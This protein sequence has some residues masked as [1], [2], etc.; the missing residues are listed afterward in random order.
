MTQR[1]TPSVDKKERRWSPSW[2][3]VGVWIPALVYFI[4]SRLPRSG[5]HA[6]ALADRLQVYHDRECLS[7]QSEIVYSNTPC[8]EVKKSGGGVATRLALS[9]GLHLLW[10][11]EEA[12]EGTA[13]A[14]TTTL[15]VDSAWQH[16]PESGR[17]AVVL[18]QANDD[19][20]VWRWETGGGPIPLGRTLVLDQ[21]GCRS[22]ACPR[23]DTTEEGAMSLRGV[24]GL[25]VTSNHKDK[26]AKPLLVLAEWGEGRIIRLEVETGARTPL[27]MHVPA[28]DACRPLAN[29]STIT[30]TTP[31][32]PE[33]WQRLQQPQDLLWTPQGDLLFLDR[34]DCPH[35]ST[36]STMVLWRRRAAA[37]IPALSDLRTSRQAHAWTRLEGQDQSDDWDVLL[38][39][40]TLGGL[41]LAP[42]GQSVY[43]TASIPAVGVVIFHVHLQDEDDD[44]ED[45][46]ESSSDR[47]ASSLEP[48]IVFRLQRYLPTALEAGPLV[49]TASGKLVLA[50]NEGLALLLPPKVEASLNN[51]P[52]SSGAYR[53]AGLVPLPIMNRPRITSLTLGADN[54]LYMTT[55][56][57]LWRM[58][59]REGPPSHKA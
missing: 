3:W 7:L 26:D 2:A 59:L 20:R 18:S 27:V 32:P 8:Q 4:S 13:A 25:T 48:R 12:T 54:Y 28:H 15:L 38:T 44:D 31:S 29:N 53:L 1:Q 24:G 56:T 36:T 49:V 17:G 40:D 5:L 19:G 55:E 47:K 46:E 23:Q 16:N 50:T 58:K 42:D 9:Q 33:N 11:A 52:N 34:L 35:A 43:V 45:D 10:N 41:T 39:A 30:T 21:A 14:T 37:Q 57:R 22:Q 51:K 6:D